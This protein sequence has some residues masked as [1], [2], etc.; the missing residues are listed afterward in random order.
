MITVAAPIRPTTSCVEKSSTPLAPRVRL[1]VT[2]TFRLVRCSCFDVKLENGALS[3]KSAMPYGP[4]PTGIVAVSA[5]V[6]VENTDTV[7]VPLP[8]YN[9]ALSAMRSEE[10]TSELQSRLHL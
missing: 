7:P 10:Q 4:L 3:R 5:F 2:L 8:R 1:P 9:D 6:A